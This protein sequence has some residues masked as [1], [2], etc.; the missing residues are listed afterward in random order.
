VDI[1]WLERL[2]AGRILKIGN[3]FKRGRIYSIV[4]S[5][6]ALSAIPLSFALSSYFQFQKFERSK[7]SLQSISD[8]AAVAGAWVYFTK[9]NNTDVDRK[10]ASD[11]A[12]EKILR[13]WEAG[14]SYVTNVTWRI[15]TDPAQRRFD[16]EVL[17]DSVSTLSVLPLIKNVPIKVSSSVDPTRRSV[18]VALILDSSS[19]MTDLDRFTAMRRAAKDY[20]ND[21]ID[22]GGP[23]VKISVVPWASLVNIKSQAPAPPNDTA[24]RDVDYLTDGSRLPP[25]QPSQSRLPWLA[26][27][28]DP[29]LALTEGSLLSLSR[30]TQWRGCIRSAPGEVIIDDTGTVTKAID[31]QPPVGRMWPIAT[32]QSSIQVPFKGECEAFEWVEPQTEPEEPYPGRPS[33]ARFRPLP[34]QSVFHRK[35]ATRAA[36]VRQCVRWSYSNSIH[37]CLDPSSS[38]PLTQ[39]LNGTLNAF[40]AADQDCSEG[41]ASSNVTKTGVNRACLS[42]PNEIDYFIAGGA[43]CPWEKSAFEPI[44]YSVWAPAYTPISGPNLNCPAAILPLSSNRQQIFDKLNE[45]Y[46]VPGGSQADVGLAWALRTL[47]PNP[48]WTQFWG[49]DDQTKPSPFGRGARKVAV[50]ITDGRNEVPEDYEGYYGCTRDSRRRAGACWRSENVKNLNFSSLNALTLSACQVMRETYGIK[51]YV[52]LTN[53]DDPKARA[54]ATL[55]TGQSTAVITTD[56]EDMDD[57][58]KQSFS[59]LFLAA[60]DR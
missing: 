7:T 14:Q 2:M 32:L 60:K 49:M 3:I 5:L 11:G 17:A 30:P 34:P 15:D 55:C 46:P 22:V 4:L 45:L 26:E 40:M 35:A 12:I 10:I 8:Q 13:R 9:R 50:L 59:D 23:G 1:D 21:L 53:G 43:V 42:D 25:P 36:L 19:S 54:F 18:E 56:G 27:P 37:Q 57:L 52:I 48:F 44:D 20:V 33:Q 16:L 28:L 31:D 39:H 6:L 29:S 51:L 24:T 38:N 58:L 47:S 41:L